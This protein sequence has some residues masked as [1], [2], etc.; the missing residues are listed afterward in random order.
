MSDS[1]FSEEAAMTI[2]QYIHIEDFEESLHVEEEP[3]Q[4]MQY[5]IPVAKIKFVPPNDLVP[6]TLLIARTMQGCTSMRLLRVLFDSGGTV[7][8]VNR[9]CLPKGCNPHVLDKAITSN[10]ISGTM[11]TKCVVKLEGIVLP[12]FDRNKKIDEQMALVFDGPSKYDLILGRDFLQKI[13][14]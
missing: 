2:D 8:M 12:E 10:T 5:N 4:L 1:Q 13:G 3:L 9:R 11:K 6:S 14:L 7:T